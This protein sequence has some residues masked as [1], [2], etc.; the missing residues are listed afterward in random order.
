M[1]DA[2]SALGAQQ[3]AGGWV[4]RRGKAKRGMGT[5]AGAQIGGVVGAAV[6]GGIS[7]KGG[8]PQPTPETPDF[9]AF[10]YLAVSATDLVLVRGKQGLTGLKMTDDVVAKVPRGDVVSADL[11]KGTIASALSIWFA[12]GV[13]W[14][15]EVARASK[16][17]GE[18]I[19]A[20]LGG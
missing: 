10:G 18:R 17:A 13:R 9:G 14:E 19:V 5:V 3:V 2:S 15:L 12:D 1:A 6:A 16:G 4:N 7:G 20:E 8:S 11:G